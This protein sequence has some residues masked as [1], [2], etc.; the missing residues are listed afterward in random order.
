MP[1]LHPEQLLWPSNDE[2]WAGLMLP[3]TL[4]LIGNN[5]GDWLCLRIGRGNDVTEVIQWSHAGGDW[6]PLGQTLSEALIFDVALHV[7][8]TRRTKFVEQDLPREQVF[9]AADW[10]ANRGT[11]E[12][13]RF[14]S[15][16]SQC[17]PRQ[18]LESLAESGVA[19]SAVRRELALIH[20]GSEFK[21]RSNPKTAIELNT[22]WRPDFVRWLFD[23]DLI[24]NARIQQ[25][26][27]KWRLSPETL[28]DQ[29]W[30]AAEQAAMAVADQRG[31]LSWALDIAGWAAERRGDAAQAA[32]RYWRG[33]RSSVFADD[34]I[35]FRTQ[36]FPDRFGKFSA[37]RLDAMQ[38]QLPP[39][40]T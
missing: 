32:A 9:A 13:D 10:A 14:W 11:L 4:P 36:W 24:P 18:L 35:L 15:D 5:Y 39:A 23:T 28:L 20:L 22:S 21:Q 16:H 25:L 27:S 31:D 7:T 29:D 33:L 12:R 3:D 30:A 38:E 2:I 6:S 37:F 40:V 17:E 26:T 19:V 34:S 1:P 8:D